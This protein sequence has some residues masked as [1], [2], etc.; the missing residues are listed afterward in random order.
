MGYPIIEEGILLEDLEPAFEGVD[1]LGNPIEKG[2]RPWKKPA[3]PESPE[4]GMADFFF[5]F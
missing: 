2:G 5:P 1:A 3:P 4:K